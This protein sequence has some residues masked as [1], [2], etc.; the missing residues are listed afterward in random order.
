MVK[1]RVCRY[2]YYIMIEDCCFVCGSRDFSDDWFDLVIV[3]D[4]ELRIVK[5]FR[6]SI[7]EVVKVFGKYV[8]R[9]R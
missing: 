1:E 4:V 2:C 6:E 3:L 8:I 9:V 7:L 5:K